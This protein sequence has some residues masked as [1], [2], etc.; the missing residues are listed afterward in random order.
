MLCGHLL[1]ERDVLGRSL[2]L[3]LSN[4]GYRI[5]LG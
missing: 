4:T 2:C 5:D 1:P 3:F